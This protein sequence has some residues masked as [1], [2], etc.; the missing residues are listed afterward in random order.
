MTTAAVAAAEERPELT[1]STGRLLG[2]RDCQS[3][4]PHPW[5][6]CCRDTD[7]SMV[8]SAPCVGS[9]GPV[10]AAGVPRLGQNTDVPPPGTLKHHAAQGEGSSGT[11]GHSTGVAPSPQ[12]RSRSPQPRPARGSLVNVYSASLAPA[13]H[14]GNHASCA[15]PSAPPPRGAGM[16]RG[17]TTDPH[18][19]HHPTV[20]YG[21]GGAR[22]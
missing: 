13:H 21:A 17:V 2:T 1:A 19:S 5:V 14:H 20:L 11:K 16:A 12:P 8:M 4:T 6:L 9:W 3:V 15:P 18:H 22:G 10:H 7:D